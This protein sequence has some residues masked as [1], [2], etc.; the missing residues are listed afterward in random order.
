MLSERL[1]A[2]RESVAHLRDVASQIDPDRYTA[3]AYPSEWTVA[4]TF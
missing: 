2:L 3:A 4:D 1:E